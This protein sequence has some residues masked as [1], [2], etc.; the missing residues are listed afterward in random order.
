MMS[1]LMHFR[2]EEDAAAVSTTTSGQ[3]S[4]METPRTAGAS[5]FTSAGVTLSG[6]SGTGS[7]GTPTRLLGREGLPP[8]LQSWLIPIGELEYQRRPSG[9]PV[10]I[11]SG[12]R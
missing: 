9:G 8:S 4:G 10:V 3:T 12:A 7:G 5:G 2:A 11:G 6:G 1:E